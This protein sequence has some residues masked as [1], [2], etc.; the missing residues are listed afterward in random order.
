MQV[1][2][3]FGKIWEDRSDTIVLGIFQD[4]ENLHGTLN[5]VDKALNGQIGRLI[6][7]GMITGKTEELIVI[8]PDGKTPAGQ[9]ILVGVG[10]PEDLHLGVL[11]RASAVSAKRAQELGAR[12]CLQH[13]TPSIMAIFQSQI[14]LKPWPKGR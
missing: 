13:C 12:P 3:A 11:R 9:V 6:G 1:D 5:H 10:K 4:S 7:K 14:R 2:A 8:H